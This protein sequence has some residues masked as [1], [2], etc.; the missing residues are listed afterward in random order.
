[1]PLIVNTHFTPAQRLGG[2]YRTVIMF[3]RPNFWSFWSCAGLLWLLACAVLRANRSND[4]E[5]GFIGNLW[6]SQSAGSSFNLRFASSAL[7]AYCPWAVGNHHRRV[8]RS[9]RH[10]I[11][12]AVP[13]KT[14][15]DHQPTGHL[16][17]LKSGYLAAAVPENGRLFFSQ[18]NPAH[19]HFIAM[20]TVEFGV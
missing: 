4:L 8:T 14:E 12:L 11:K 2:Q 10:P 13:F 19:S 20:P 15:L 9:V 18:I 1:M 17:P 3:Q 6:H 5:L 7:P 16:E